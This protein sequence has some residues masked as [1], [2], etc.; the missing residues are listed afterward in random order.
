MADHA[1]RW[2]LACLSATLIAGGAFGASI[3]PH[4]RRWGAP[5]TPPR[6]AS[7]DGLH[8][9]WTGTPLARSDPTVI[10]IPRIGVSAQIIPLGL[11]ANGTAAIPP[12]SRPQVTSW[13]DRGPTPGQ[14]GTAVIFGHVDAKK[15]GPAVFYRIGTLRPGNL[16]YVTL[17]DR[18]VAAFRIYSVALVPKSR[19]P[20][21]TVYGYTRRPTLRLISCGGSF[22]R[23]THH[24]RSNV[25]VF[26]AF[27]GAR[28]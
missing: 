24:Y 17:R 13:F 15:V 14:R 20:T 3:G 22:D 27:V 19:F 6:W 18:Q 10:S 25:V 23:R 21:A 9:R 26:A 11:K 8:G 28:R 7:R 4:Q 12:L 16:I 5:A 1:V 2:W